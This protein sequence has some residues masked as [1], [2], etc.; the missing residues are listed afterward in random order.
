MSCV[1]KMIFHPDRLRPLVAN[2]LEVGETLIRR[3]HREAVGGV[4]DE[5]LKQVLAEILAYPGMPHSWRTTDPS[6]PLLPII[7]VVFKK[8]DRVFN[9]FST[10]TT[11]GTAQDVT[12]QEIR[13]E[14]FFPVDESTREAA[15]A[16]VQR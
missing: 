2:W 1:L 4:P 10:V 11:L 3:A 16:L 5:S 8:G 13:I 9:Y 6:M 12:V 14:C 15:R 7:P